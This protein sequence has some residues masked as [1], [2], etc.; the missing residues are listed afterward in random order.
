MVVGA[1]VLLATYAGFY[2]ALLAPAEIGD[3][4]LA[5]WSGC[6]IPAYRAGGRFAETAFRPAHWVDRQI[7]PDYWAWHEETCDDPLGPL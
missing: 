2:A 7:R 5:H 1:A 4:G 6:R 3:G